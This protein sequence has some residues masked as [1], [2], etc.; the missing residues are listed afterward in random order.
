MIQVTRLD[1]MEYFI[2][3]YQI[4]RIEVKPDTMLVM[5]SGK[6]Y[7]VREEVDDVLGKIETYHKRISPLVIQE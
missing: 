5:Q 3:P 7:I 4:E 1:G 6:H 2:N